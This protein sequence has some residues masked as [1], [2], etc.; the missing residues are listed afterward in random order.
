MLLQK[1]KTKNKNKNSEKSATDLQVFAFY[2][3]HSLLTHQSKFTFI[4][5]FVLVSQVI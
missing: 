3:N 5:V 2:F 4:C 1:T